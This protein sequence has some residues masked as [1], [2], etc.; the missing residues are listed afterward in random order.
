[1]TATHLPDSAPAGTTAATSQ[2]PRIAA[3][4]FLRGLALTIVL[5]DHVDDVIDKTS[6]FADWTLKGL[7][8]SDAAEVFVFLS[9]FT[10]GRV[11][12]RR[13]D[14]NGFWFCQRRALIRAG[15]VYAAMVLTALVVVL[16]AWGVSGT[17][18]AFRLPLIVTTPTMLREEV[19]ATAT[20]RA[21]VWG[22]AILAVYAVVLP[23]LPLV[24]AVA[25]RSTVLAVALTIGI[26]A[27]SQ[28]I[29]AMN[30]GDAIFN[31]LAWQLL[32]VGGMILGQGRFNQVERLISRRGVLRGAVSVLV[33][34]LIVAKLPSV[35]P[36]EDGFS[37]W[38]NAL[39]LSSPLFSKI[40]LGLVRVL[41]FAAL[42]LVAVRVLNRWPGI[43]SGRW[44]QPLIWSGRYSLPL[45]CLGVLLAYAAA[46][47][48]AFLPD[49]PLSLLFLGIDAVAIQ[50]GA[51]WWLEA[52]RQRRHAAMTVSS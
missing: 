34:G 18:L 49:S 5:V 2:G 47:G 25:R 8:F 43:P 33:V 50:F 42:A 27:G 13:M 30:L 45:F 4:D 11:Y 23:I 20:L 52:R 29:P 37:R 12:A 22:V 26:Y 51:A 9:G 46:L 7:G 38:L 6:L 48:S 39:T 36:A 21:P 24:L 10:F 15:T 16:L 31:P 35:L 17:A 14:V 1:M 28:W 32:I 3:L 40:N 41:H 19:I 44:A